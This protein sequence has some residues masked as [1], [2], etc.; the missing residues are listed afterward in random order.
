MIGK[1]EELTLLALAR[2]RGDALANEV[3]SFVV[4]GQA[5]AAFGAVYTTLTRLSRKGLVEET[6]VADEQGRKRRGFKITG[7]GRAALLEAITA[8]A[9]VGGWEVPAWA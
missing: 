9:S 1:L 5:S 4:Q 2:T 3:F 7:G 6:I 8:S